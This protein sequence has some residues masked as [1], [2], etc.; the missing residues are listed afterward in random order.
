MRDEV[1]K[2]K[3]SPIKQKFGYPARQS[4]VVF[5]DKHEEIYGDGQWVL[6]V[7]QAYDM[8]YVA[9]TVKPGDVSYMTDNTVPAHRYYI[10]QAYMLD[11]VASVPN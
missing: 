2:V 10:S 4:E 6:N 9:H 3:S 7:G 1:L 8:E 11:F 5:G